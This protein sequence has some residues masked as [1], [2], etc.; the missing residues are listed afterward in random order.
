MHLCETKN[1]KQKTK[2]KKQKTKNKKQKTKNKEQTKK[3]SNIMIESYLFIY[4]FLYYIFLITKN[5]IKLNKIKE[6]MTLRQNHE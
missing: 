4:L 6:V 1:K 2:N 3:I 5:M